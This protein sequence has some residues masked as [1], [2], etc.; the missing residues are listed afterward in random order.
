MIVLVS[1]SVN[2]LLKSACFHFRVQVNREAGVHK[3]R[4]NFYTE[5]KLM[6][7]FLARWINSH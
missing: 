4:F 1:S 3:Q 5:E 7:L 6:I 2:L